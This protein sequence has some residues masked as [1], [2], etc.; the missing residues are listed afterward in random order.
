[1]NT[2]SCTIK[3]LPMHQWTRAATT[4]TRI[5]PVNAPATGVLRATAPGVVIGPLY[6]AALTT[7]YWGASGVRL[8]VGFLDNPPANLRTRILSHMNAWGQWSNVRFALTMGDAQV[9]IA[10]SPDGYWSYLGTDILHIPI[11][12]PTMNLQG[13]TMNTP[14]AEFRRVVRHET[15]HTLGFIHEH[16]RQEITNRIDAEKAIAYFMATQGWPR[17]EVINQVLTPQPKS[18]L[19][20]TAQADTHSIMCYWLPDSIMQ[21]GVAVTGG[22]DIDA[23]DAQFASMLYPR[24]VSPSSVW[25]NGKVYFFKGPQYAQYDVVSDR[26]D[27]GHPKPIQGHWVGFPASFAA[28][29]NAV[30]GGGNGKVYFFSGSQYLQYDIA[31]DRVDSGYPQPIASGWPGLWADTIDAAILWPNAK[32]YFFKGSRYMRYD[33]TTN[34]VDPGYPKPI[35]GNWPGFPASFAAGVNAAVLWNNGKSY[36]FKGNEYIR[37]DIASDKTDT[38]YPQPIKGNWPGLWETGVDA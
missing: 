25:P 11:D 5:N 24:P 17:Q 33:V 20:A 12:Q 36:F 35:Q 16:M 34:R 7:R 3:S 1:M 18:A 4:A 23:Q 22:A 15:G 10:R 31:T 13:F 37:Y 28:G 29:V 2:I 26:V 6:T 27:V 32:V 38:G 14:D 21:D 19:L 9:R 8:T 30:V